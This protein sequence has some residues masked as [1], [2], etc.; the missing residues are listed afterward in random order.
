M[1]SDLVSFIGEKDYDES[2]FHNRVERIFIDDHNVP[3][4]L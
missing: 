3:T 1:L 4:L 2:L